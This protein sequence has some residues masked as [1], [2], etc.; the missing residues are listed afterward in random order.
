MEKIIANF[1]IQLGGKPEKIVEDTIETVE[2]KLKEEK[3]KFKLLD[4][5]ASELDLDNE[6]SLFFTTIDV[7]VEFTSVNEIFNFITDYNPTS[8]EVESPSKMKMDLHD[9]NEVLNNVSGIVLESFKEI[10]EL[11]AY[12]HHLH[13][14]LGI[15]KDGKPL[16]K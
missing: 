7:S 16:K 6:S 12:V 3:E 4:F 1:L 5:E 13:E 9:T 15:G 10:R 11:R 2:K 14:K 8:V